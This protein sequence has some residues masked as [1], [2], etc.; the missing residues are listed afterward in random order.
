MTAIHVKTEDHTPAAVEFTAP[1]NLMELLRQAGYEQIAALCGGNCSC[2]TCHVQLADPESAQLFAEPSLIEQ[3]LLELA[4]EY[5][6]G[7]SRLSC[8][9]VL[10]DVHDGL[11]IQVPSSGW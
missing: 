8:Q 6:A 7:Q 3:E 4:D 9:L 5:Q 11:V 2:A 10:E 1:A